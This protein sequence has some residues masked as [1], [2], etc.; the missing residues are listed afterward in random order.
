MYKRFINLLKLAFR[1]VSYDSFSIELQDIFPEGEVNFVIFSY[2]I[3]YSW[4]NKM[5]GF[6]SVN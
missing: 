6:L 2:F 3:S 1:R 4:I 5:L